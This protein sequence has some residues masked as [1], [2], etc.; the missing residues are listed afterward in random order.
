[1]VIKD[2]HTNH[3]TKLETRIESNIAIDEQLMV[4]MNHNRDFYRFHDFR[5]EQFLF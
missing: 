2:L 5:L 3:R 1:M 4:L